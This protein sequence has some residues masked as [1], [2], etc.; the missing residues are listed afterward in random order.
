MS[1]VCGILVALACLELAEASKK[2]PLPPVVDEAIKKNASSIILYVAIAVLS[3]SFLALMTI[4]KSS[5]GGKVIGVM[6]AMPPEIAMLNKYVKNIK[7]VK[8]NDSL[9]I[10]T[11]TYA[12]KQG[13]SF[14]S[15][16]PVRSSSRL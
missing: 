12:G 2:V 6:G 10:F 3:L 15:T 14:R 7:E 1:S 5:P 8:V 16:I 13:G 11:G 9:T 4:F